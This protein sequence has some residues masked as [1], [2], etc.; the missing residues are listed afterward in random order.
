MRMVQKN[1]KIT[2][3]FSDVCNF[4]YKKSVQFV[5]KYLHK[6]I[7]LCTELQFFPLNTI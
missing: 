1:Y 7:R 4:F 3:V 5:F 6:G 2:V